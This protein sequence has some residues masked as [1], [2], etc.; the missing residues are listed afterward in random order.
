MSYN[1]AVQAI[2]TAIL[3]SRYEA[4]KAGNVIQLHLYY[5]I[6]GYI[7][8][9]SRQG[10]WGTGAIAAISEQLK[11]ELPGLRGYSASSLK[12]M[13]SFYEAWSPLDAVHNSPDATGDLGATDGSIKVHRMRLANLPD[14]TEE[15]FLS[16]GFSHHCLILTKVKDQ[17]ERLFYIRRCAAEHYSVD[18]LK[19]SIARDD[20]RHQGQLPNNFLW[21]LPKNQQALRAIATFKDEYLLDFIN[22]EELNARDLEDVD[23]RVLE[24]GI[25]HNI[26][27]FIM[28]FGRDFAFVG[29]QYHLEAFGED[30]YVDLLF[31]NRGLNCLVAVELKVGPFKTAYLG[32]LSGYLSMLDGFVRKEHEN[33]SVGIVL[34]KDMNKAFVNYVVRDYDKPMGVATYKT[35]KDMPEELLHALPPIEELAALLEGSESSWTM[36]DSKAEG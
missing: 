19:R 34:C 26:K 5:A 2:K 16:I 23:E 31:F 25:V 10:H 33:P 4:G 7:S 18:A 11:K 8:A 15:D 30:Q 13:R 9:N 35:S 28:E 27:N 24:Q 36:H 6:G 17:E 3:Q 29:N 1:D 32:Q 22:V 12:N 21:T 20:Y 14:T